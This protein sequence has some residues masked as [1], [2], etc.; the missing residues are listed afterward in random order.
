MSV[1]AT[2]NSLFQA[3]DNQVSMGYGQQQSTFGSYSTPTASTG[4]IYGTVNLINFNGEHLFNNGIWV[5]VNADTSFGAGPAGYAT[6]TSLVNYAN[7]SDYGINT[8]VGYA[9]IVLEDHLQLIPYAM[10]GLNNVFSSV[11]T[12]VTRLANP[13][14]ANAYQYT[15]AG[16]ARLEYRI[17]DVAFLYA[18]QIFVYNWDASGIQNGVLSQNNV[19]YTSTIGS[20]FNVAENIQ[21]GIKGFWTGY[22]PQSG[23][24]MSQGPGYFMYQPQ[25]SVGGL[26]SVGLTY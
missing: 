1:H 7:T 15:F 12:P 11:I 21:L 4:N 9:F 6:P 22:I 16:G 3:F 25:S 17:N 23:A 14:V 19:A 10:F 24:G 13:Q 8:K 5:N 18:D 20:K 26:V 2:H